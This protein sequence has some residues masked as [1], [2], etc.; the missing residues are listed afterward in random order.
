MYYVT[1]ISLFFVYIIIYN[2]IQPSGLLSCHQL[3]ESAFDNPIIHHFTA[4]NLFYESNMHVYTY[5]V[6]Q[7]TNK[8]VYNQLIQSETTTQHS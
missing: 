3:L 8:T 6:I 4:M 7:I 5:I 2:S 1:K